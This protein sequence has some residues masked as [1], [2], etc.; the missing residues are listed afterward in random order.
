MR[1]HHLIEGRDAPLYHATDGLRA[2]NIIAHNRIDARTSSSRVFAK[3]ISLT[4]DRVFAHHWWQYDWPNVGRVVFVLDQAA[5][6]RGGAKLHPESHPE[7]QHFG[8]DQAE[9]FHIGPITDLSKVLLAVEMTEVTFHYLS[10]LD[11]HDLGR[12]RPGIDNPG[13]ARL[14]ALL[15][16]PKVRIL[17]G[18]DR[19]RSEPRRAISTPGG[20]R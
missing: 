16:H 7:S 6:V 1:L 19:Y 4:R 13:A 17:P 3:G 11:R 10:S 12:P 9:E 20:A 14:K 18:K 2:A 8:G 5:M 15:K